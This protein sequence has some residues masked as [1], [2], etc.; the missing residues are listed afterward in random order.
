MLE[1]VSRGW[2]GIPRAIATAIGAWLRP[3]QN[4]QETTS[5]ILGQTLNHP[6]GQD[7]TPIRTQNQTQ[8]PI[9]PDAAKV[10]RSDASTIDFGSR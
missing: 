5:L 8:T 4:A 6:T 10:I 2:A 7:Q 3:P 9:L 1:S